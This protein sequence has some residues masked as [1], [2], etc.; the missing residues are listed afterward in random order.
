MREIKRNRMY[1]HFKGENYFTLSISE[2]TDVINSI[3]KFRFVRVRHTETNELFDILVNLE[4]GKAIH[5]SKI[6]DKKLVIYRNAYQNVGDIW[7]RD[8]DMFAEILDEK[9][10]PGHAGVYRFEEIR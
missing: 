3:G 2:P 5:N 7:A 4:T 9:E 1:K 8:L 10:Y 6:S